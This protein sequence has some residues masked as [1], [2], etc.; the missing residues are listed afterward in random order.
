[1]Q[2]IK[3]HSDT[4]DKSQDSM[5]ED[6]TPTEQ[7]EKDTIALNRKSPRPRSYT[8]ETDSQNIIDLSSPA[9][10]VFAE[11]HRKANKIMKLS[12]E[13]IEVAGDASAATCY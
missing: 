7:L 6:L 9:N 10:I 3:V 4:D 5:G 13:D 1:M 12:E 11:K 8:I 2:P